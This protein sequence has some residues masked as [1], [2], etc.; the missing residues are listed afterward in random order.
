GHVSHQ[1]RRRERAWRERAHTTSVWAP[2]AV[3]NP[4]VILR[5]PERY[6]T[7][8]IAEKECRYFGARQAFLNHEARTG[9]SELLVDHRGPH[10]GL[11]LSTIGRDC[12][13]LAG[14]Q[15]VRFDDHRE[16]KLAAGDCLQRA[17]QIVAN[18]KP[19]RW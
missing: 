6:R 3:K 1:C 18:G 12:H 9:G 5:C 16:S 13:T 15:T 19:R 14:R 17:G 4:F 10:G 2:I 8:A 11:C 7:L